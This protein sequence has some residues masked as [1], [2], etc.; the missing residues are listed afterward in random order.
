MFLL[1]HL[2]E[3]KLTPAVAPKAIALVY[4]PVDYGLLC[5]K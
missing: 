3:N 1:D 5:D 4:Q 2:P